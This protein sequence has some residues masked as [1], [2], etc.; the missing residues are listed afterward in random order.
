MKLL[1]KTITLIMILSIC[2]V[3]KINP[4]Y[5]SNESYERILAKLERQKVQEE[6]GKANKRKPLE[7]L[8][9][10]FEHENLP[11]LDG[12][13]VMKKK[14]VKRIETPIRK[15]ITSVQCN[16]RL[17]FEDRPFEKEVVVSPQGQDYFGFHSLYP[18]TQNG[19]SNPAQ[20]KNADYQTFGLKGVI[21]ANEITYNYTLKLVN[22]FDNPSFP[23]Q[24]L[25]KGKLVFEDISRNK[26]SGTGYEIEYTPECRGYVRDEIVFELVKENYSAVA[27][28]EN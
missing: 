6:S 13:W 7:K 17:P 9:L 8:V 16:S 21:T 22:H 3:V 27:N 15:A 14:S 23:R 28:N 25:F 19:Y 26:I 18:V 11:I 2:F 4:G 5:C 20:T 10:T 12:T 24:L 1:N